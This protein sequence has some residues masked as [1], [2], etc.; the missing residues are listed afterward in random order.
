M[1][2]ELS[3]AIDI[4][5]QAVDLLEKSA[6]GG[7]TITEQLQKSHVKEYSR[8]TA[9]GASVS[10]KEH[11]DSRH[12]N[13]IGQATK[14]DHPDAK[15]AYSFEHKG[16]PYES[17]GKKGTSMHDGRKIREFEHEKTGHRIWLDH[18]AN[19]HADSK[20]EAD[21]HHKRGMYADHTAEDA[22]EHANHL[23][24]KAQKSGKTEDHMAA[25]DAHH[26]AAKVG[27]AG[28]RDFHKESAKEHDTAAHPQAD[29]NSHKWDSLSDEENPAYTFQTANSKALGKMATGKADAKQHAKEELA[30][31]GQDSNTKWVGFG[32]ADK[33]HGIT[34]ERRKEI[35]A[36]DVE[37]EDN[38]SGHF[39]MVHGDILSAA[40]KG[41]LDL[42]KQAKH[43]LANRG[44]DETGK[45]IGFDAAKKHH[46]IK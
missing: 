28:D 2:N 23:S 1:T 5:T 14:M 35:N 30:N 39:Q 44:Q 16:K 19:V 7:S 12:P 46:G 33:H 4:A 3:K 8:T 9:S 6:P 21:K 38:P 18:K 37:A 42:Q 17:T 43:E 26:H 15:E 10:V 11:D 45:W 22:T 34:P 25:A 20:E 41:H 27:E 36:A 40:A 13:I 24:T 31:R 32:A 29:S